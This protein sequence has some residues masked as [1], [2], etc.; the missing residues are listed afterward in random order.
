[1][2]SLPSCS[3]AYII[4][5]DDT[6]VSVV[7]VSLPEAPGFSVLR[8]PLPKGGGAPLGP[9]GG[10]GALLET[11]FGLRGAAGGWAP[12]RGWAPLHL[13]QLQV[14]LLTAGERRL[15]SDQVWV[16]VRIADCLTGVRG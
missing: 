11:G 3:P 9:Q 1:M 14:Y 16:Q 2:S 4:C 6:S 13:G 15:E 5:T 8:L 10:D 12:P 7:R